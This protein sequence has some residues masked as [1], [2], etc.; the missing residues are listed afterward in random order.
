M[1]ELFQVPMAAITATDVADFLS[2]ERG[3]EKDVESL[4]AF[5]QVT[6]YSLRPPY[7]LITFGR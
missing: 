1:G 5:M 3:N 7:N 6:I 4:Y 2:F